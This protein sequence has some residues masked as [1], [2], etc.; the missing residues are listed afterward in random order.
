MKKRLVLITLS[1]LCFGISGCQN[2]QP[3]NVVLSDDDLQISQEGDVISDDIVPEADTAVYGQGVTL[4]YRGEESFN[5]L[6]EEDA[7]FIRNLFLDD[8]RY[9]QTAP[10]CLMDC[11]LNLDGIEIQ[12]HTDCG[13]LMRMDNGTCM[14]LTEEEKSQ[15]NELFGK[16]LGLGFS[17]EP[18]STAPEVWAC[19]IGMSSGRIL[20][21]EDS[22]VICGILSE[23]SRFDDGTID[24]FG[25]YMF[26]ADGIRYS[27]HSDC[28]T[29]NDLKNGRC[30]SL[31]DS[32][33]ELVDG[34]LI[35]YFD[36]MFVDVKN[37]VLV[38]KS[39]PNLDE[40]NA[41]VEHLSEAEADVIAPILSDSSRFINDL[42]KCTSDCTVSVN[43][44]MYNYCSSCGTFNDKNNNRGLLLTDAEKE[45]VN[46]ILSRYT[47]L[48]SESDSMPPSSKP[49]GENTQTETDDSWGLTLRADDV[50]AEGLT[51][52][53][54]QE[55]GVENAELLSGSFFVIE[56]Y[57]G[58]EWVPVETVFSQYEI[59]WTQEAWLISANSKS[60]WKVNWTFLYGTLD[61]GKY[62]I[63]KSV[64]YFRGTGDYD[65]KLYY[66]EFEILDPGVELSKKWGV[67][68]EAKNVSSKGMLLYC[69]QDGPTLGK[70]VTFEDRKYSA[71]TV[72]MEYWL[73]KSVGD[74]WV[75]LSYLTEDTVPI[76]SQMYEMI[77]LDTTMSWDLEWENLYGNLPEGKYRIGKKINGKL[78]DGVYDTFNI[79][80]EFEIAKTPEYL[81][82][83]E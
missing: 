42:Y 63:G 82:G 57:S 16:Y 61:A 52:T 8:S 13:N 39:N 26:S 3:Q 6:S 51:L 46:E 70:S 1:A 32:E 47:S 55:G 33:K 2:E 59:T 80:S 65:S 66:A 64:S 19:P 18:E 62:R 15:V 35:K 43:G 12:Y 27:Y 14:K 20:S 17:E 81:F 40:P 60:E 9:V 4:S 38:V 68:I 75:K 53:F 72:G 44:I 56:K 73:E 77:E 83:G 7:S 49:Q 74:E 29:F 24:C 10:N 79:Y 41:Y 21:A 36:F 67:Y 11:F 54:I 76:W 37:E 30:L 23:E 58:G 5:I 78:E 45:A 50:S 71:M 28:G 34:I 48:S 31:S 69:V 22:K 25:D